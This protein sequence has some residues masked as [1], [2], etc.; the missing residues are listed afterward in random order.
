MW[1][2]TK[3]IL[4]YIVTKAELGGAQEHV[5][6]LIKAFYL[7]YEVH[8][9][10]SSWGPLADEATDLGVT[11]HFLPNLVRNISVFRDLKA[12]QECLTLFKRI[13]PHLVHAHSSK[14]GMVARVAGW[15][16]H[17]PTIFT[18][19]GW[20]FT[21]GTPLARRLIA[22]L[23]EKLLRPLASQI[24][25]VS[26]FDRQLAIDLHIGSSKSFVTIRNG[27][28]DLSLP[29]ADPTC[30][31]PQIIMVARFNEQKDQATLLKAI[32]QLNNAS[33]HVTFVGSGPALASC[34]DLA[35]AL[36]VAEQ[37]SFLGDR[38]DVAVLLSR[39]Q[40]F[41]LSTHYEGL[42][43]SILEAMRAG[44]PVIATSVSGI[45]EVVEDG[46][47]GL[48]V[49]HN[50]SQALAQALQT[51]IESPQLRQRLGDAGRR[52]FLQEFSV[53]RMITA[54]RTVYDKTRKRTLAR[55]SY[56]HNQYPKRLLGKH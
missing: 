6:T 39:A 29:V 26:E 43:I 33:I 10:V 35:T 38:R 24:I 8:L 40:I 19:H 15:L 3:P 25:C 44:L 11:V 32:S 45:P 28:P 7:D 27:I 55:D 20:G 14:A 53:E 47:T 21:P 9:A 31:P 18:S 41:V 56:Q 50:N 13:R 49:P 4:L 22:W 37:I 23:T 34:K 17:V 48:L 2:T 30:H 51:L 12:I 46:Q 54:T 16:G 42:P 5:L 1:D 52:R 36:G